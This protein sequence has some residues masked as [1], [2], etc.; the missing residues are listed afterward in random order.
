MFKTSPSI[1]GV[2]YIIIIIIIII[3]KVY[4]IIIIAKCADAISRFSLTYFRYLYNYV[5]DEL[6]FP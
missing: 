6:S 3:I 4:A 1:V 5:Y 2:T